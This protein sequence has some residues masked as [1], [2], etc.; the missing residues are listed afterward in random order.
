MTQAQEPVAVLGIG[1]MGHAMAACALRAG[2][3]T[4][5]WNR[6]PGPTHDIAEVGAEVA[7]TATDAARRAAIVVTMVTMLTRSCRSLVT[8]AC[9]P[10]WRRTRSGRR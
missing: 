4:I 6:D 3:P 2:I 5:V 10:R 7:E 9:L 1:V 8:R